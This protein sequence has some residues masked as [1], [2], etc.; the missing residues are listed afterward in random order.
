MLGLSGS[1]QAGESTTFCTIKCIDPCGSPSYG[2]SREDIN[3]IIKIKLNFI[4]SCLFYRS[5]DR[6]NKFEAYNASSRSQC[7]NLVLDL[8]TSKATM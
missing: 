2:S 6:K 5:V 8:S 3:V 4:L 7:L 1:S